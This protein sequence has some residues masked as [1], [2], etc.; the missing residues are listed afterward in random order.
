MGGEQVSEHVCAP[1]HVCILCRHPQGAAPRAPCRASQGTHPRRLHSQ[2]H[3][4]LAGGRWQVPWEGGGDELPLT[5]SVPS[6]AGAP[7]A[8]ALTPGAF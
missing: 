8:A 7:W 6:G 3:V 5:D 1:E 2:R 4:T